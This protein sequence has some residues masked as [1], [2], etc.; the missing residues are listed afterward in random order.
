[1]S[2]LLDQILELFALK[3]N[4]AQVPQHISLTRI[5]PGL[6]HMLQRLEEIG[7]R[8]FNIVFLQILVTEFLEISTL[9]HT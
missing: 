7:F 4:I 6:F 5:V 3:K 9:I 8:I 1:M 2:E